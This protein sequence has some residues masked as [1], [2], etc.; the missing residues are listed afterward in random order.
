MK[1]LFVCIF[2]LVMLNCANQDQNS[3]QVNVSIQKHADSLLQDAKIN[4]VSI[5]VFKNGKKYTAHFGELDKG[6]KNTPTDA[7]IYEIASVSKTL[8]GILVANA[9]LEGKLALEEDVR[10]YLN[11]TLSGLTHDEKPIKIKHLLAHTSGLPKM[12]PQS[13]N[14]LFTEFNESL[15]FKVYEVQK[16]YSKRDFFQDL[17]TFEFTVEPG[18]KY[19]YSNADTELMAQILENVYAKPFDAILK[20][21]FS[22]NADMQ[23]TQIHLIENQ[24]QYL[25]NGYGMSNKIVPHEHVLYGADGGVKTTIPDLL[26]Y[27]EFQLDTTNQVVQE[28]HK[29]LYETK[30]RKIGYYMPI[31][32]HDDYGTYYSM[33]GGGFGS[34]NWFYVLPKYN[35]GISVITNQSDLDTANKLLKV[36]KGLIEDLK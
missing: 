22:E 30:N 21:Y 4:A 26:N 12:L 29:V 33:H 24:K 3:N 9:V 27:M 18:T 15:P 17:N 31:R 1:K 25:A 5:G 28:S 35:L 19:E 16:A 6:E 20:D 34:Q 11:D 13:L 8:T 10:Y 23:N 36:V 32:N 14:D 2:S 7:T